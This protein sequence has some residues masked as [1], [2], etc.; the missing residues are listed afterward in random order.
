MD[1]CKCRQGK[2][3]LIFDSL[4]RDSALRCGGEWRGSE[5][6][7]PGSGQGRTVG[8]EDIAAVEAGGEIGEDW[9]VAI[10]SG[11][12]LWQMCGPRRR[13]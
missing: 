3:K 2:E 13:W 8:G 1:V 7:T 12:E 6:T 11:E 10:E 4:S 5:G 9:E